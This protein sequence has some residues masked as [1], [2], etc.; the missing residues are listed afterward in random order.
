[1][2]KENWSAERTI[3]NFKIAAHQML[4]NRA[5][6]QV[7]DLLKQQKPMSIVKIKK[8]IHDDV[9]THTHI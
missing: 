8:G 2:N 4:S 6:Y 1:M 9:H 7:F 3:K 5:W